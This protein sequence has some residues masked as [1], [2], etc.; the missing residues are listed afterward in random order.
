MKGLKKRGKKAITACSSGI[1]CSMYDNIKAQT[2]HLCYG[3][4]T[5]DMPS[6]MVLPRSSSLRHCMQK[7]KAEDTIIWDEAG[8]SSK[9]TLELNF[10]SYGSWINT[11]TPNHLEENKSF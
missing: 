2:M 10:T 1:S 3:L 6:H 8:M 7:I 4:Q 5:A 9:R 11:T